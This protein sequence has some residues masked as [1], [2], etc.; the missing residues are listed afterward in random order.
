MEWFNEAADSHANEALGDPA[1]FQALVIVPAHCWRR[2]WPNT[3]GGAGDFL[4]FYMVVATALNKVR[5]GWEGKGRAYAGRP[6]AA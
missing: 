4:H 6:A 5:R 2:C 3:H 1:F